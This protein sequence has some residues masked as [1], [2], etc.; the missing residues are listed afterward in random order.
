[1]A[2]S[3]TEKVVW[4]YDS[5]AQPYVE[6][7]SQPSSP[8]Q[9]KEY[10]RSEIDIIEEAYQ[11]KS[12][13][14]CLD[15]YR[16][17]LKKFTQVRIDDDSKRRAVRRES[18]SN[19]KSGISSNRL[20]DTQAVAVL[21]GTSAFGSSYSWCPFLKAWFRSPLGK[22]VIVN[23]QAY[24]EPCAQGIIQE[25]LNH[26]DS[27]RTR[28]AEM[29]GKLRQYFGKSRRDVSHLCMAFYTQETFLY[30]V[31]NMRASPS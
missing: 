20:T 30:R 5:S 15:Q 2:A 14:V 29:A 4:Y 13:P 10:D 1:M 28:A 23:F 7:P 3:N 27:S 31:L 8:P 22:W 9:W 16:I 21:Q 6:G 26:D 18:G 12:E 24:I 17:E 11:A 19:V 25:A